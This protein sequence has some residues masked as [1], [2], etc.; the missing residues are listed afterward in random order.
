MQFLKI[1]TGNTILC[2]QT[3]FYGLKSNTVCND[4]MR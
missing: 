3:L 4:F 2:Y 1:G